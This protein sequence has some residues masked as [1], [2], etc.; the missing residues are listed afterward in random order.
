MRFRFSIRDLLLITVIVGLATGWWLDHRRLT[1]PPPPKALTARPSSL[2][3][4]VTFTA[5]Q[6]GV[7]NFDAD[8]GLPYDQRSKVIPFGL[9]TGE[10][11]PAK[12]SPPP[13]LLDNL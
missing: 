11:W 4:P 3:P 1:A 8:E 12:P 10:T 9:K 7:R 6:A 13:V 2:L 5:P